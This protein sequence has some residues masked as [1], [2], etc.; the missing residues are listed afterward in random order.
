M[1][2]PDSPARRRSAMTE[3]GYIDA[4]SGRKLA[5]ALFLRDVSLGADLHEFFDADH[6]L[7][8]ILAAIQQSY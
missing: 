7:G 2:T 8:A 3:A 1:P 6:D 4:A 5:F